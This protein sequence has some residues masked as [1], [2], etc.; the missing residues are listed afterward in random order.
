M[1]CSYC[2]RDGANYIW[3]N[4]RDPHFLGRICCESCMINFI[5]KSP[6]T[7]ITAKHINSVAGNMAFVARI[8]HELN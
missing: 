8:I 7:Q 4:K 1:I 6:E 5:H 3:V 2:D